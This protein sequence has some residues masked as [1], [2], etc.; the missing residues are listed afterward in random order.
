VLGS[1]AAGDAELLASVDALRLRSSSASPAN[2][3]SLEVGGG[4]ESVAEIGWGGPGLGGMRG[5][6]GGPVLEMDG[7]EASADR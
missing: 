1:E 6:G 2:D 4:A 5:R 7:Y 3:G